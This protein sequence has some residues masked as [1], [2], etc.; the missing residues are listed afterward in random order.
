MTSNLFFRS[1]GATH[2]KVVFSDI[3]LEDTKRHYILRLCEMEA[4]CASIREIIRIVIPAKRKDLLMRLLSKYPTAI[5]VM[6]SKYG[7]RRF[8]S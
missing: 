2:E 7:Q 6:W 5:R 4:E 1:R 8:T 3:S